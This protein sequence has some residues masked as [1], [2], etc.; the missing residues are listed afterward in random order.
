MDGPA[1]VR[2]LVVDDESLTRASIVSNL[3]CI[4]GVE[5]V[6]EAGDVVEARQ[7]LET[8]KPDALFVDILMPGGSGIELARELGSEVTVVF[9]TAH[10]DFAVEAFELDAADYLTKPVRLVRL[11]EA[12]LRVRRALARAEDPDA[13][14]DGAEREPGEQGE[15]RSQD[16]LLDEQGSISHFVA[17]KHHRIRLVPVDSLLWAEAAGNYVKL[18]ATSGT[19]LIRSTLHEL[20]AGLDSSHFRRIHRSTIVSLAEID[21]ITSDGHGS[22]EVHLRS[23]SLLRMTRTYRSNLIP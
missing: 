7:F 6:G 2:V 23:G 17:K 22:Y 18:H 19:H 4:D 14:A 1:P 8:C 9:V 16:L 12:V 15:E 5:V 10:E 11:R 3:R 20:E 13:G 21:E